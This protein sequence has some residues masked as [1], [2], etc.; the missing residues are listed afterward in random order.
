MR[1]RARDAMLEGDTL[2]CAACS[3]SF[4]LRLA[5]ARRRDRLRLAPVPLLRDGGEVRVAVAA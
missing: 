5:G 1:R 2:S 3:H 4:E